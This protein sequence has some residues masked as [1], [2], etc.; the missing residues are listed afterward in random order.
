MLTDE[1]RAAIEEA[2][3]LFEVFDNGG[4]PE[5]VAHDRALAATL[6]A[7]LERVAPTPRARGR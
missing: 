7:L 4:E 6:R 1:E 3:E 2:A 5:D